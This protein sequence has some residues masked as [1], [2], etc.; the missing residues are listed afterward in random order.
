MRRA[1]MI[2]QYFTV[3]RGADG[4]SVR[5]SVIEMTAIEV[6]AAVAWQGVA[7][8]RLERTGTSDTRLAGALDQGDSLDSIIR[9]AMPL[10][11]RPM[12]LAEALDLW[13]PEALPRP[14]TGLLARLKAACRRRIRHGP[15]TFRY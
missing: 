3:G 1:P 14:C 15:S 12:T 6:A 4:R 8:R 7:I 10:W 11:H 2:S 13:W 5:K 9:S